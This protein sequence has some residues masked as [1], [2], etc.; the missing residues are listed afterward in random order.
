MISI[1]AWDGKKL[2]RKIAP[3]DF[4]KFAKRKG[5]LLWADFENPSEKEYKILEEAFSFHPLTIED[6]KN[7]SMPKIDEF[8]DY[9]FVIF[10][11]IN[12]D[13]KRGGLG[14]EE[15]KIY[16]GKG[17]V[18]SVHIHKSPSIE[19]M[20][21]KIEQ[22]PGFMKKGADFIMHGIVD[23][24]VD[25]YFAVI[26]YWD[27]KIDRIEDS[28]LSGKTGNI[29]SHIIVVRKG[30]TE[31]KRNIEP[32]RDLINR[33][34]RG[35]MPFISMKS[36]IYFRDIYDHIS[37]VHLML[38]EQRDLIA[39]NFEAYLSVISNR[40]N[41]IMKKLTIVATVFMPITFITGLYGMNFRYMPEL[42]LEYGYFAVLLLMLVIGLGML[43][44]FRRKEWL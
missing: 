24:S 1:S 9:I 42:G 12:F 21:T 32:L 10:H 38:E 34:T 33:F 6:C 23:H 13:E 18:V 26:D 2:I 5:H 43:F 8:D 25:Q 16:L 37:R 3:K 15:I 22:N 36:T 14:V 20:K 11:N 35:G 19:A 40:M 17:F 39:N 44:Y 29:L 27:K 31:M 28:I 30:V 4:L 41:E 7:S